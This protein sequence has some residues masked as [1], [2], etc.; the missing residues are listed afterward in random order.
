[1]KNSLLAFLVLT[2]LLTINVKAD[3][4]MWLPSL[5]GKLN[6]RKMSSIGCKLTDEQIY[7][8]NHSS[9]KDAVVALDRGSCTAEIGV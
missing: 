8:I 9:L 7:S 5:V 4:G 1:M 2:L 6:I 3:E